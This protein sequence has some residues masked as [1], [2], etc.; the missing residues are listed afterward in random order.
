MI[1]MFFISTLNW[2]EDL[3]KEIKKQFD[4]LGTMGKNGTYYNLIIAK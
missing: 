1:K 3:M 2:D 4:V